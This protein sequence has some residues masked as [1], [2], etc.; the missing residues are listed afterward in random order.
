MCFEDV[1]VGICIAGGMVL[2]VLGYAL[3]KKHQKTNSKTNGKPS[4]DHDK[5]PV[6]SE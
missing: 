3:F 1:L 5:H 4:S 6:S 2:G